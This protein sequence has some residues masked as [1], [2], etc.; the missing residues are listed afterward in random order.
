MTTFPDFPTTLLKIASLFASPGLQASER[1]R[2]SGSDMRFN[3]FE[4]RGKALFEIVYHALS[5]PPD[6]TVRRDLELHIAAL[7][8][9]LDALALHT[10]T[11]GA[12][13]RQILW[14]LLGHD[15][16]PG[17]GRTW[18]FWR[19]DEPIMPMLPG[20]HLWFLPRVQPQDAGRVIL[21]IEV[22]A[23]WW[24][25]LLEG[26]V[27]RIWEHEED[28]RHRTFQT[29]LSGRATP[30]P[31]KIEEW[32]SDDMKFDYR[33]EIGSPPLT[34]TVRI[35][36]LWARALEAGWKDLVGALSPG[37][38]PTDPDP[39]RNKALQLVELFRLSH[40]LTVA[41][42]TQDPALADRAFRKA[43]PDWLAQGPFRQILPA[44]GGS[45]A[46]SEE[47]ARMLSLRFKGL[48]PGGALQDIFA[49]AALNSPAELALDAAVLAER[50]QIEQCRDAALSAWRSD[51]PDRAARVEAA[52]TQLRADPRAAEI[53]ADILHIEALDALSKGEF[54][55][56]GKRLDRGLE[57]CSR[58]AFGSIRLKIAR[59]RLALSVAADAFNQNKCEAAFRVILRSIERTEAERWELWRAPRE[60]TMRLAAVD[61]SAWFWES[62]V[63]PYPGVNI[64][65]P[66]TESAPIFQ[67][68]FH[69]LSAGP[70]EAQV[71]KFIGD[72]KVLLRRKLRDVRGDTFFTM[73]TKM[74]PSLADRMESM[75]S[76]SIDR[77]F[78]SPTSPQELAAMMRK[79]HHLL[80]RMLP[81]DVLD[82]RD[83]LGQTA[84]MLTADRGNH[85]MLRILIE[86]RVDLD[87]QD[88]LGR[89]ALHAAVKANSPE[90]FHS[91]LIAGANPN[92]H[93][94][95]DKT[96][97]VLAAEL[98]RERIFRLRLAFAT[99]PLLNEELRSA[100]ERAS[101]IER[102]YKKARVRY[103]QLGVKIG[104]RQ[105]Y[106]EI[107]AVSNHDA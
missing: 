39:M 31:S 102:T 24:R 99:R 70:D 4:E 33:A 58:G 84:L 22:I 103:R 38:D 54:G 87:A 57:I 46:G 96:P 81:T 26:S 44:D 94:C 8:A 80:A 75:P 21:P 92:L 30:T 50:R 41:S 69:L 28:D 98:G 76:V 14:T 3:K 52:L 72:H 83:Y 48:T 85:D 74:A 64:E 1:R 93:T 7:G 5:L 88:T 45:L 35:L 55:V 29:W 79:T 65:H 47:G 34:R 73:A 66:L 40:Q 107:M 89:T 56:A 10:A 67:A 95:E 6:S 43:V 20:G 77:S 13:D 19:L 25:G 2:F 90:C 17:L 105:A 12:D 9:R 49:D 63:R 18:G 51:R 16:A 42:G 37:I 36:L 104:G 32:F 86:K 78:G 100:H 62:C 15:L 59:L 53:E 97:A 23:K 11:F 82:A 68:Y 61:F 71:R 60:H 106:R 101:L 91:L 27:E